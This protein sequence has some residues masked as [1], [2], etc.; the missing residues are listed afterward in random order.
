MK[1]LNIKKRFL[2]SYFLKVF[3][4]IKKNPRTYFY[5]I[6]LDF[7]FLAL[8]L[9]IGKYLGS[10]IPQDPQQLMN[11]F[12][13]RSNLLLFVLIY[14]LVY[15]L[16]IIF[17]YSMAK[18]GI[19]NIIKSLY[20]KNRLSLK[21]LRKFYLL[22]ISIF[23]ILFFSA[24]ILLGILSLIL[25]RDFLK[26]VVLILLI[27]FL[28]FFYSIINISHTLFIKGMKKGIIKKSFTVAFNKIPKYGTFI[29][30]N[31]GL[32]L[33]YL[34]FYNIIHLLFRFTLFTNQQLLTTYG[35]IYLKI[36]NMLSIIFIYLIIA[37]NRIY[38]YERIGEN[39]LQ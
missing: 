15:Y 4:I 18:L 5:T 16:F 34:L 12:K 36:F 31:I 27:P 3:N 9:F 23:I 22:N 20:K 30:W 6:I 32:T 26:Y 17:I 35:S 13:A 25:K 7:I 10:L 24:L 38:F 29:L 33:I 8:I 2:E 1:N 39:V 21:G 28:F 14:P 11:F 37:F 19:L